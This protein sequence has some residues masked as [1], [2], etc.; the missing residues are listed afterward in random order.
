MKL[1]DTNIT[2][3]A[4]IIN[5]VHTK[6]DAMFAVLVEEVT[7]KTYLTSTGSYS[8]DEH[9]TKTLYVIPGLFARNYRLAERLVYEHGEHM[10]VGNWNQDHRGLITAQLAS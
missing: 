5:M 4:K 2:I 6:S 8:H 7:T 3:E 10:V 9:E 1:A